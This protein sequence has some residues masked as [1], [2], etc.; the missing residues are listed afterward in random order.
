M[1]SA[2]KKYLANSLAV[3]LVLYPT[4]RASARTPTRSAAAQA[5]VP[6][7]T[8][9][10]QVVKAHTIFI[11]NG[12]GDNYF[13]IFSGGSDRAY[14]TLEADL[15]QSQQYRIVD[16]P[17]DADV[18]F[19]IHAIAP[20]TG[21]GDNAGPDPQ[22]VLRVLD[23]ATNTLLWT[24]TA[25]VQDFGTKAR[26]DRGFDQ[27]VAVLLDKLAQATGQPLS[28]QQTKAVAS[29][30][31]MSTAMKVLLIGG[32]AAGATMLGIILYRVTHPPTL[33]TPSLPAQPAF[34]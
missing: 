26:R 10:P 15:S 33:A 16:S 7:A 28:P 4:V 19:E 6:V 32:V 17:R 34:P 27:S 1:I 13:N 22:L 23:S 9:P 24:T 2:F 8:A 29:N 3:V 18:I 14:N 11:A 25:N 31:H 30:A 20:V 5:S 12:G 21:S